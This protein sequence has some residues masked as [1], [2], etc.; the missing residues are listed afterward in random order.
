[1]CV[2]AGG[3]GNRSRILEA[4]A[5][6]R[7]I[8]HPPLPIVCGATLLCSCVYRGGEEKARARTHTHSDVL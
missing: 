1:M 6:Q 3:G 4:C 2:G 5:R 7:R 8:P